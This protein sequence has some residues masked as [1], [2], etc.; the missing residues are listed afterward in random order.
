[1]A[2]VSN[3]HGM[4]VIDDTN[5]AQ[6][7]PEP[8]GKSKGYEGRNY[9]AHPFGS[10]PYMK[11]LD[12]ASFDRQEIKQRAEERERKKSRLVDLHKHYKLRVLDQ[13]GTNYCWCYAVVGGMQV[14]RAVQG[15]PKIKLS[16]AS[17]AAKIKG[18]RNVGGWGGEAVEGIAKFGVSTL[19]YWPEAS[20][21][22]AKYNTHEQQLN[23]E[24]NK[25][26]EFYEIPPRDFLAV[27]TCLVLGLPV[28]AGLNWWRHEVLFLDVVI[29]ANGQLGILFLNSWGPDWDNQGFGIL[30][31]SKA[32]PD[33]C[34]AIRAVTASMAA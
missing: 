25:I 33:E 13:N 4:T 17:A 29:L 30:T 1:M 3:V 2:F 27:C 10:L 18:G 22:I 34:T 28:P 31:E 19:D 32:T 8:T 14:A 6:Y 12:I 15:L 24:Q 26:F 21:D 11:T 23:A 5:Y 20:R 7:I 16:A 9:G